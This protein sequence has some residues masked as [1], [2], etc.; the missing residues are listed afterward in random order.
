MRSHRAEILSLF[1]IYSFLSFFLSLTTALALP[2][3]SS[4]SQPRLRAQPGNTTQ[5][6]LPP[7]A[8]A[9]IKN[10]KNNNDSNND[11]FTFIPKGPLPTTTPIP[12]CIRALSHTPLLQIPTFL[13]TVHVPG[14][15][16]P[17]SQGT[18][19]WGGGL[20]DN[21][22][23]ACGEISGWQA[24]PDGWPV[25]TVGGD[26]N[27]NNSMTSEAVQGKEGDEAGKGKEGIEALFFSPVCRLQDVEDATYAASLGEGG[28]EGV[29]VKCEFAR[30]GG[31]VEPLR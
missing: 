5:I 12:T 16:L 15:M 20:L 14:H 30:G 2:P 17:S 23:G 13:W 3:S 9:V 19:E 1:S 28:G 26:K 21:L 22:R 6:S 10:N 8:V 7:A 25:V 31:E 4:H 11:P 29:R 27:K 24:W 18:G